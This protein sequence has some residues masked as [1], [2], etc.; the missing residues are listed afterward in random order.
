MDID[1][2]HRL[3]EPARVRGELSVHELWLRHLALGGHGDAFDIDGY[4][5]GLLPLDTLEQD[6]LAVALNERLDEVYRAA[7]IPIPMTGP[8]DAGDD[9]LQSLV[10]DLLRGGSPTPRTREQPD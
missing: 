2:R 1:D 9:V 4:L 8:D 10:E 3:F 6:I 7:R 5:Q